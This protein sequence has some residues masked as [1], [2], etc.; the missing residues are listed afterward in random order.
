MGASLA[1]ALTMTRGSL[2]MAELSVLLL[3]YRAKETQHFTKNL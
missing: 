3:T 2:I 1:L